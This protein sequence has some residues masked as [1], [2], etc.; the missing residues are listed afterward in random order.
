MTE[1]DIFNASCGA[2]ED[3]TSRALVMV[4]T[5]E[6]IVTNETEKILTEFS[7]DNPVV[8]IHRG[9]AQ[10]IIDLTF[11]DS[12]DYDFVHIFKALKEFTNP[13]NSVGEL[14]K[15]IP[16]IQVTVIPK[17]LMGD[18]FVSGL[19]ASWCAMPSEAGGD[20]NTIRFIFQNEYLHCFKTN[21][22]WEDVNDDI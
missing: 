12:E 5:K 15:S 21:D 16:T 22:N 18:Y 6:F 14:A 2:M 19:H 20:I 4:E 8:N 17:G 7:C 10:T 1:K 11:E 9:F 13:N 3:G